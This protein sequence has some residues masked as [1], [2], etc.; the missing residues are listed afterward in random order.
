ML[1]LAAAGWLILS[2]PALSAVVAPPARYLFLFE[3]QVTGVAEAS[4]PSVDIAPFLE[5]GDPVRGE[6]AVDLYP[7]P[8]LSQELA[9]G[10]LLEYRADDIQE[11]GGRARMWFDTRP[12]F[13]NHTVVF[14]L[15][16]CAGR[17]L[18]DHLDAEVMDVQ[19]FGYAGL[20]SEAFFLEWGLTAGVVQQLA[21]STGQTDPS[22]WFTY[23]GRWTGRVLGVPEPGPLALCLGGLLALSAAVLRRRA[24]PSRPMAIRPRA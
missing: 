5:M 21:S 22:H 18:F 8:R 6:I 23:S 17:I 24:R 20:V 11:N 2:H 16:C 1:L 9:G 14:A 15:E 7:E 10:T 12:A 3:G 19:G 13:G 4:G